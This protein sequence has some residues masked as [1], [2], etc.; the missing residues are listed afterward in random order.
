MKKN[1]DITKPRYCKQILPVPWL[2]TW[3]FFF[4]CITITWVI[5]TVCY[6]LWTSLNRGFHCIIFSF[7]LL[8]DLGPSNLTSSSPLLI[9]YDYIS[10]L[11]H[12]IFCLILLF[13]HGSSLLF[14]VGFLTR[15][16]FATMI[17]TAATHSLLVSPVAY[18]PEASKFPIFTC[19][20]KCWVFYF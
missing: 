3:R 9:Y 20:E 10:F 19:L 8:T 14:A 11:N 18:N 2:V 15:S 4:K 13:Q 16:L 12:I 5:K 6:T 17:L 1:L 7:Q